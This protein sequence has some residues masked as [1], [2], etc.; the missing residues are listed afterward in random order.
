MN[1]RRPARLLK[2]SRENSA[3]EG[4]FGTYSGLS[5]FCQVGPLKANIPQHMIVEVTGIETAV[6]G[7]AFA[8]E[9]ARQ[10]GRLR[11]LA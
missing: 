10:Q 7:D 1:L 5:G 11:G 4:N 2:R 3:D 9:T 8:L 6:S